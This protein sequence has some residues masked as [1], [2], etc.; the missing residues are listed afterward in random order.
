[1]NNKEY[2]IENSKPLLWLSIGENCLPDGILKRHDLKS[3]S[4]PYSH[5]RT[6]IDYAIELEKQ[7]YA[8]LLSK[9]NLVY[10]DTWGGAKVVRS[11]H[12][13]KSDDLYDISS[14][15]GFEFTH[16]DTISSEKDIES[17]NRKIERLL[18]IRKKQ[19]V[20]FLYHHRKNQ[21]TD[22]TQINLKLE[23]FRQ[24]YKAEATTC[25]VAFFYQTII[26]DKSERRLEARINEGNILEFNYYTELLWGGNDQDVFWAKNDDDLI[27][28]MFIQIERNIK[29]TQPIQKLNL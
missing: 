13:K 8:T 15:K 21:K 18:S 10:E 4:T 20:I 22:I 29:L 14:S 17:Y 1:L 5:G 11:S 28:D 2:C 7:N 19:D 16:H 9:N 25:Y 23:E 6:N 27:S 24:F 26:N 3:F 12:I